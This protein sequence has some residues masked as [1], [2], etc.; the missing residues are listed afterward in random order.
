M[1]SWMVMNAA[2]INKNMIVQAAIEKED[3][4]IREKEQEKEI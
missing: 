1:S 2:R 3:D 4:A